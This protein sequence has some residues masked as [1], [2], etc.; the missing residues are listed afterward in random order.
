[1]D[2]LETICPM[3]SQILHVGQGAIIQGIVDLY[4]ESK[5]SQEDIIRISRQLR[6]FGKSDEEII[7]KLGLKQKAE[8]R[9]D[10]DYL[11]SLFGFITSRKAKD[12][13]TIRGLEYEYKEYKLQLENRFKSP[14]KPS[15]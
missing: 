11:K 4:K 9:Q 6:S 12:D 7:K 5:F 13:M 3:C 2:N 14:I 8:F 10:I 1:M 15:K